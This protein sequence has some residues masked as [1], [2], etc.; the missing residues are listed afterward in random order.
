MTRT[1]DKINIQ[2]EKNVNDLEKLLL[3][4][5]LDRSQMINEKFY[6]IWKK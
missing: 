4:A 1:I 5:Q 2:K 6:C 3:R